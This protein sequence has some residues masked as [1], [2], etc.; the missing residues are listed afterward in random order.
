MIYVHE[1]L[2]KSSESKLNVKVKL[3]RQVS[4]EVSCIGQTDFSPFSSY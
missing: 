4:I 2:R 3:Q 1:L